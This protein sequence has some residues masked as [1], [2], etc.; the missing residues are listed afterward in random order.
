MNWKVLKTEKDYNRA[1]KRLMEI[2]NAEA[3]TPED[4]ELALLIVL[5]KDYDERHYQLPQV[6]VLDVIK[7]KMQEQGLKNKDLEPIIGSK[8]HVSSILSG[9]REI[10]LKMAQ[11]LRDYFNLPAEMFLHAS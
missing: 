1:T 9:R 8:G 6:D 7:D 11:R 10:T 2:F 5:I 3:N 4:E